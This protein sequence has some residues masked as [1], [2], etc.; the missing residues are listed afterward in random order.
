MISPK[1]EENFCTYL[2]VIYCA[3]FYS[4]GTQPLAHNKSI[5]LHT[6]YSYLHVPLDET[7]L[8]GP[9]SFIGPKGSPKQLIMPPERSSGPTV[10]IT[11]IASKLPR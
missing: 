3:Y 5:L 7:G 9:M 10:R 6:C 11:F 8:I 1:I 2:K 4:K